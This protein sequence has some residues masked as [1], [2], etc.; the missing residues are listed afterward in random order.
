MT[1]FYYKCKTDK[2][3]MYID[4]LDPTVL[5][6][7]ESNLASETGDSSGKGKVCCKHG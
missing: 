7:N 4:S 6:Y 2:E 1:L 5:K 3:S